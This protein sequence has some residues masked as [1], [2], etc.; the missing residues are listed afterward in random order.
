MAVHSKVPT[1]AVKASCK[2][3]SHG[4]H[5]NPKKRC[6]LC[7]GPFEPVNEDNGD[8]LL[9]G[10]SR[11]ESW[12]SGFYVGEPDGFDIGQGE[13]A[14]AAA[15]TAPADLVQVSRRVIHRPDARPVLPPVRQGVCCHIGR[16][17]T[18]EGKEGA[19][20]AWLHVAHESTEL[21]VLR[22]VHCGSDFVHCSIKP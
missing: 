3:V 10:Q 4:R 17:I 1:E 6:D 22:R 13:N 15:R 11:K 16:A 12:E 7:V 21:L 9:L 19:P 8:A 5:G 2:M 14:L 18:D 20:K